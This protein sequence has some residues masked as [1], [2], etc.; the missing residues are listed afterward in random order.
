[1][2]LVNEKHVSRLQ[3]SEQ[4]GKVSGLVQHRARRHFHVHSHF[5]CYDMGQGGFSQS[6]R[7]VEQDMVQRLGAHLCGFYIDAKIGN[8]FLL[9]GEVLQ[10]LRTDYSLKFTIFALYC[11][12][13]IEVRHAG[14]G[15]NSDTNIVF[16]F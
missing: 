15:S 2:D 3:G 10:S 6:G 1:M 5:I 7:A 14:L 4:A 11:V 8:D 12:V 13:W 9:T 16:I